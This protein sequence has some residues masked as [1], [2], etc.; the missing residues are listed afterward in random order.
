M[1]KVIDIC[2]R[3][4]QRKVQD[5]IMDFKVDFRLICSK[6]GDEL[7]RTGSRDVLIEKAVMYDAA[8]FPVR[9]QQLCSLNGSDIWIDLLDD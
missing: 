8:H 9:M 5:T 7:F 1:G 3:L 6:F 2:S 4:P